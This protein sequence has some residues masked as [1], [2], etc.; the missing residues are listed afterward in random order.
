MMTDSGAWE[1]LIRSAESGE[2]YL[3]Q[4][5][6]RACAAHCATLLRQLRSIRDRAAELGEVD[7]FGMLPS[8]QSL[9]E[10]FGRKAIGGDYS[11]VQALTDHIEVVDQM[12]AVFETI[13]A[14]F[15]DVDNDT[16]SSFR[17]VEHG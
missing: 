12:R 2:L 10:K 8:G 7:G 3:E 17:G 9:A 11:L 16:A 1:G 13:D 4:G 14:R 5:T 6:A 15:S